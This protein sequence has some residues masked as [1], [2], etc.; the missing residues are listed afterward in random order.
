[1][2]GKKFIHVKSYVRRMPKKIGTEKKEKKL[3]AEYKLRVKFGAHRNL[4][5]EEWKK[6]YLCE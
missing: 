1:M 4:P 3:K 2:A 6:W 5:Y